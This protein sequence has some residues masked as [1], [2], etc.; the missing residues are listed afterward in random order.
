MCFG[1][2]ADLWYPPLESDTP[3]L[4]YSVSRVVCRQ[5]P[6]WRECLQDGLEEKYGLWGGLTPQERTVLTTDTPKQN[7]IR[8]HGTWLRFRQ[9]C[10]CSECTSA[11]YEKIDKINIEK[12]PN[13]GET[14]TDLEMLK[15]AIIP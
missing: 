3:E 9:G 2:N 4:Y 14:L 6:V 10:R 15:F 8:A 11:E 7:A 13:V 1:K 5:C 12:I